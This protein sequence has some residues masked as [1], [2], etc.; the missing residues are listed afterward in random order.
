MG[1]YHYDR[2]I[3]INFI[4]DLD[5]FDEYL[6]K[7]TYLMVPSSP[8]DLLALSIAICSRKAIANTRVYVAIAMAG[9]TNILQK[10]R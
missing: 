2:Q 8:I 5:C 9:L 3:G 10:R 1:S 4:R 6:L 7:D